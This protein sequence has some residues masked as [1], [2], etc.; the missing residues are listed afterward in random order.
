MF[1]NFIT[2]A[3]RRTT[4]YIINHTYHINMCVHLFGYIFICTYLLKTRCHK[5]YP[6][7]IVKHSVISYSILALCQFL[8]FR[9]QSILLNSFYNLKM[10]CNY[11]FEKH[12]SRQWLSLRPLP[13]SHA[14]THMRAHIYIYVNVCACI[15]NTHMHIYTHIYTRTCTYIQ[16]AHIHTHTPSLYPFRTSEETTHYRVTKMVH[17]GNRTEHFCSV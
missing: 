12:W 7:L 8:L 11:C 3:T 13:Q 6:F 4:F 17:H 2:R 14:C 1:F 16:Y 5:I 9:F 15:H 10:S